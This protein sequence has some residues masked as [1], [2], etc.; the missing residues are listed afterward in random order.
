M[1]EPYDYES[2]EQFRARQREQE[3]R[4]RTMQEDPPPGHDWP[5][6]EGPPP[7][8]EDI[9]QLLEGATMGPYG[10]GGEAIPQETW[11]PQPGDPGYGL[12]QLDEPQFVPGE[13]QPTELVGAEYVAAG[14]PMVAP[15]LPAPMVA[16][17]P[18]A[19]VVAPT[20][21]D[22]SQLQRV[23]RAAA[24]SAPAAP[25]TREQRRQLYATGIETSEKSRADLLV[26]K[27]NN[28]KAQGRDEEAA[29]LFGNALK[30]KE[31][32]LLDEARTNA[33]TR[34][35][36]FHKKRT[37]ELAN[38]HQQKADSDYFK[39]SSTGG[40]ISMI[41]MGMM[42]GWLQTFRKDG[43]NI[44]LE[45]LNKMI[46]RWADEEQENYNRQKDALTD[47]RNMFI[48]SQ[49]IEQN[50]INHRKNVI[51]RMETSLKTEMEQIG[52]K[53]GHLD[54]AAVIQEAALE[55]GEQ[56]A[57]KL[58]GMHLADEQREL[59]KTRYEAGH[60][61]AKYKAATAR[62]SVGVQRGRL[63]L[64]QKKFDAEQ[65]ADANK[66]LRDW[67]DQ[68]GPADER[69]VPFLQGTGDK[70]SFK[71]DKMIKAEGITKYFGRQ[72]NRNEVRK[73][74]LK[75]LSM[76]SSEGRIYGG[77]L[78]SYIGSTEAGEMKQLL[79]GLRR[80]VGFE[81]FGSTSTKTQDDA[82]KDI[83]GD[84]ATFMQLNATKGYTLIRNY[85]DMVGDAQYMDDRQHLVA[86]FRDVRQGFKAPSVKAL[87]PKE[88]GAWKKARGEVLSGYLATFEEDKA[89]AAPKQIPG[90]GVIK[91]ELLPP[92]A[93]AGPA[94]KLAIE[95]PA[96]AKKQVD[97]A[98]KI[99]RKKGSTAEDKYSALEIALDQAYKVY[100]GTPPP[101]GEE[102]G[103]L[104]D[105]PRE[106]YLR[107]MQRSLNARQ[108]YF[109]IRKLTSHFLTETGE[110]D[111]NITVDGK[112]FKTN[113]EADN[114]LG[115]KYPPVVHPGISKRTGKTY[116]EGFQ[117]TEK[118]VEKV[119]KGH[120]LRSAWR[121]KWKKLT[122][123]EMIFEHKR[124]GTL[125][126]GYNYRR[127]PSKRKQDR[128]NRLTREQ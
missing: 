96:L 32:E 62:G 98:I 36:N 22:D 4:D 66:A 55:L 26:D 25:G 103:E 122:R 40:K 93:P 101:K 125:H 86:G 72:H 68:G 79:E 73:K 64:E 43:K 34:A 82:L 127:E 102:P 12:S 119:G 39:K 83:V 59:E 116:D 84:V 48:D 81:L 23:E 42:G 63:A 18:V 37:D 115:K 2:P 51:V 50:E 97:N 90:V 30:W 49:R 100:E 126:S 15:S 54:S 124:L 7:R 118:A 80:K 69:T 29:Q 1:N 107:Q 27:A 95:A 57:A 61:L 47:K 16:P 13:D 117:A 104:Q 114:A 35:R 111:L 109:K 110:R 76:M 70:G 19:P 121:R 120:L 123:A 74:G 28:L 112:T 113:Q 46:D 65:L 87:K 94:P 8:E 108:Q 75:L 85:I 56:T 6:P 106:K 11:L 31:E 20:A 41:L 71:P 99:S 24:P 14:T 67:M 45:Y 89:E 105:V 91:E 5:V 128:I 21:Q 38:L 17:P 9:S 60:K 58:E 3:M 52:R 78:S 44:G 53:Y 92:A 88:W 33:T 77:P 10:V